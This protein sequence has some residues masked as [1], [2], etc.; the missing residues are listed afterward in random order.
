MSLCGLGGT[1]WRA[2][3]RAVLAAGEYLCDRLCDGRLFCDTEHD[4]PH[5]HVQSPKVASGRV[6]QSTHISSATPT[7]NDICEESLC[8]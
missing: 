7:A 8:S 4:H 2:A 6:A 3:D 1:R 5:L